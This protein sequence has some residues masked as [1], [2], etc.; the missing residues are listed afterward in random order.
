MAKNALIYDGYSAIFLIMRSFKTSKV[1]LFQ[2]DPTPGFGLATPMNGGAKEFYE[3]ALSK[4]IIADLQE[5]GTAE[6]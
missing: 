5:H 6:F 4:D 2:L 1:K 3:G